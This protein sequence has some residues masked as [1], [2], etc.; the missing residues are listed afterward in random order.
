MLKVAIITDSNS[1]ITQA[2]AKELGVYVVP[3]PF[4]IDGEE[5]FEGIN[6][7]QE[8]FYEKLLEDAEISTSQPSPER[9][10]KLWDNLLEEYEELVYIPMSSGLSGS[11][12]TAA[13]LAQDYEGRV[14]V[15]DNQRIS[16]SLRSSVLDALALAGQ[17]RSAAE[18]KERLEE[19]KLE[20]SI[21]LMVPTL[22]YLKKGGRVTPAA[23]AVG[24]MLRIKPV[25]QIQGEKLDAYSKARTLSQAKSTMIEALRGDMERRFGGVDAHQ[26]YLYIA[27]T[28][29]E[30]EAMKYKAEV[31]AAFPG[32]QVRFVDPLSLSVSCHIGAGALGLGCT[33][34]FEG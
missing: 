22:K 15:V 24:N 34:I 4:T 10:L 14:Q 6:L 21:Y 29:N 9:L 17:G 23:A 31:E 2:H 19:E 18:I 5:Y 32:Y 33:R 16:V 3:M 28:D 12:Q 7:T 11:C 13:A 1:G 20:A 8:Q 30:E 27:H 25:L 26:V